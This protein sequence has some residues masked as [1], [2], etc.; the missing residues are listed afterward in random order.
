M[1]DDIETVYVYNEGLGFALFRLF[2]IVLASA[3]VIRLAAV[4][5]FG[6]ATLTM[7]ASVVVWRLTAAGRS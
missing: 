7:V 4:G 2:V 1:R 5:E 6:V 3:T